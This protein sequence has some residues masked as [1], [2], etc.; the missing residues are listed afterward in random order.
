MIR[1]HFNILLLIFILWINVYAQNIAVSKIN[2]DVVILHP[3]IADNV[4]MIR[5]IGGTVVAVRT[6]D[7]ILV[8]DSF[9][10]PENNAGCLAVREMCSA[11][12]KF[13]TE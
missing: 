9:N 7:G 11:A 8:S 1:N 5:E 10:S 2:E 3:V 6:D 13:S 12:L 4:K